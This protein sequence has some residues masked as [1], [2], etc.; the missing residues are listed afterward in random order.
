MPITIPITITISNEGIAAI[1][2]A[3]GVGQPAMPPEE[4]A[5]DSPKTQLPKAW[6]EIERRRKESYRWPNK[7]EAE[8]YKPFIIYE[9]E[10]SQGTIKIAIGLCKREPVWGARRPYMVTF[11]VSPGDAIYP[12]CEFLADDEGA[13]ASVIKGAGPKKRSLY[14]ADDELPAGYGG[15]PTALYPERVHAKGVWR[16]KVVVAAENDYATM[17]AHSLIQAELR[18]GIRPK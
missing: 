7:P 4:A 14:G 1:A 18:H 3:L 9:G 5:D 17:L 16:K 12:L 11:Y 13:Y 15:L 10:T 6:R 2:A 8:I